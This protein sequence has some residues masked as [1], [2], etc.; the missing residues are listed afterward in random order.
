M[1]FNFSDIID[2][3]AVQ[4][5]VEDQ[6]QISGIPTGIIDIDGTVLVAIGWQDICSCFHR[7]HPE[8]AEKCR[9]SDDY[10]RRRLEQGD[11]LPECGYIE[12]RCKNGMID[13]GM[14]IVVHGLHLANLFLGQFFYEPP[15]EEFFRNQAHQ[16]DF[17]EQTYL[18]ALHEVPIFSQHKVQQILTYNRSLIHLLTTMAETQLKHLQSSA[19]LTEK[20]RRLRRQ[21]EALTLLDLRRSIYHGNL[22]QAVDA[23]LEMTATAL[24]L[25][26]VSVW[27]L[28]DKSLLRC[29]DAWSEDHSTH[30]E[31]LVLAVQDFPDY[32]AAFTKDYIL[33]ANDVENDPR[34]HELL[35]CYL[36]PQMIR[37]LMDTPI[38]E[39][40]NVIGMLCCEQRHQ[41]RHWQL[42]E[43]HFCNSM[44]D[45]ITLALDT[46]HRNKVLKAL[47]QSE[48]R[49][50]TFFHAT[51]VGMVIV[52][53]QGMVVEC[54]PAM[55][56]YL[57]YQEEQQLLGQ[58]VIDFTHP[59]D[60]ISS[61]Q[62]MERL[63]NGKLDHFTVE[64]R[65]LRNDGQTV[66]GH[67]SVAL[68]RDEDGIPQYSI[69]Q[70]QDIT[71]HKKAE[72][73][74]TE[75]ER[76][77]AT[78]MSNLPGM[79]YRCHN[80]RNWTVDF[81]SDGCRTLTGYSPEDLIGNKTI[82]LNDLILAEDQGRVWE[83]V[84]QSIAI[85][86]PYQ[87]EYQIKTRRGDINWVWEHGQGVYS[88]DGSLLAL[89]GF[90]GNITERKEAERHLKAALE[91]AEQAREKIDAILTSALDGLVVTDQQQRVVLMN[92]YAR[93]LSTQADQTRL[94]LPLAKL[95]TEQTF[96]N[97]VKQVINKQ[98]SEMVSEWQT[99]VLHRLPFS[100][101]EART[102]PVR[103]QAG[104]QTGTISI[105]RDVSQQRELD[106]MKTEFI[107][108][109]A[110]ELRT[111]LTAVMGFSEI[112]LH[113]A[114]FGVSE[115]KQRHEMLATIYEKAQ[116]LETIVSDL[117][118]LSR[119]QSGQLITL[120]K[121]NLDL[122]AL[123]GKVVHEEQTKSETHTITLQ[124]PEHP[125][126]A[127]A[128]AKKIE[129]VMENLLSNAC[130]F[131][132]EGS[133]IE[134]KGQHVINGFQITVSDHGQGM[135]EEQVE[136][137]FDKFYRVDASDT[138]RPGLGLGM[139]IVKSII[140]GHGGE[141]VV[142]S[143]L[144]EGTRMI[145]VLPVDRCPT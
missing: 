20:Q 39:D 110:H 99:Q 116:R 90:I 145:F 63:F 12:Y 19:E 130:K 72:E 71:L 108:T 142:H 24:E 86:K 11:T 98:S 64:K 14:P 83:K 25:S 30:P 55:W 84:E 69:A 5:L 23:V 94:K 89:E 80:D 140:Q 50:Q 35:D 136:K 111:P 141:I 97:Q 16:F 3:E 4:N 134:V 132:P 40:G 87:I 54:N 81:A 1:A 103:N 18:K 49:F 122:C 22:Q 47:R 42:D 91:E 13:I 67:T 101:I 62:Q 43:Q 109:A 34:T 48:Q 112:L 119:V 57:C 107:S 73:A 115:E 45:Y 139:S 28:E 56:K 58:K 29:I 137:V 44:A 27:L 120:K 96:L 126:L 37:S 131:S 129:Q 79:V 138:A 7:Q 31:G 127:M 95:F 77:L 124:L 33:T 121:D 70:V 93:A 117:L 144:N 21:N 125:I 133:T 76:R 10:L 6:W 9:I 59:A 128:D 53:P 135:S 113:E 66:W 102:S 74:L 15:D 8:T 143:K 26:R 106:R 78:L 82:A 32:W 17:D 38:R 2:I 52:N 60:R 68:V 114:E 75:S 92:P 36:R 51:T 88:D 85:R 105:L 104:Q 46:E 65:Y 41:P 61:Q 100:I 123:I 118:D